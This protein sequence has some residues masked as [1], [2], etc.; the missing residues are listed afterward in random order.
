MACIGLLE[1]PAADGA[2]TEGDPDL[3]FGNC[4][5]HL[6]K[7]KGHGVGHRAGHDHG[8]GVARGGYYVDAITLDIVV[9]TR[10]CCEFLLAPIAAPGIYV[11]DLQGPDCF[12]HFYS[13]SSAVGAA[14]AEFETLVD[15]WK[16]SHGIAS[17]RLSQQWPVPEGG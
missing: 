14:V 9:A 3:W 4:L 2:V 8:I 11:P 6:F 5:P 13:L 15:Q 7:R 17:Y 16:V 1:D 12:S 10:Q